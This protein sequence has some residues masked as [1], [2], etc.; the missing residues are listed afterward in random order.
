[1]RAEWVLP[2]AARGRGIDPLTDAIEEVFDPDPDTTTPED[3]KV[4]EDG[5]EEVGIM[6]VGVEDP[7]RRSSPAGNRIGLW[8]VNG[9][10]NKER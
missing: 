9:L 4:M 6:P 5:W 3:D 7:S 1:M 8:R 10:Q 2:W